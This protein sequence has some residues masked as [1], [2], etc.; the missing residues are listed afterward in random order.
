VNMF[1]LKKRRTDN[2]VRLMSQ[3]A[4]SPLLNHKLSFFETEKLLATPL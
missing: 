1:L 3:E 2:R 4:R